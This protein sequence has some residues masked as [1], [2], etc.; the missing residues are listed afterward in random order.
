MPVAQV[1]SEGGP[2]GHMSELGFGRL[3]LVDSFPVTMS[4][5]LL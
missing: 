5:A 4:G 1:R 2:E 3:Q